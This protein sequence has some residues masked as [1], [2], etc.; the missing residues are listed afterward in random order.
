MNKYLKTI[1]KLFLSLCI[2]CVMPNTLGATQEIQSLQQLQQIQKEHPV[3]LLFTA[4]WCPICQRIK[5][6]FHK[7]SKNKNFTDIRFIIVDV[8]TGNQIARKY[9]I[10]SIPHIKYIQKGTGNIVAEKIG[11][12]DNQIF[13]KSVSSD[14]EKHLQNSK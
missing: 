10:N 13:K 1:Y 11:A 9:K 2:I 7:I 12:K 6:P 8:E 5:E 3:V 14:I 4:D